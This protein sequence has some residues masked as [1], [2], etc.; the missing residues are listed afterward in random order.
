MSVCHHISGI[1]NRSEG[2]NLLGDSGR[3]Q[4][5]VAGVCLQFDCVLRVLRD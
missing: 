4:S 2:S 1:L 5:T 3:G